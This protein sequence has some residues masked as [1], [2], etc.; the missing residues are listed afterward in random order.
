MDEQEV[1]MQKRV[2]FMLFMLTLTS[3]NALADV[4]FSASDEQWLRERALSERDQNY[5]QLQQNYP[6]LE[7]YTR[8][9]LL[10]NALYHARLADA[11]RVKNAR[12]TTQ[13]EVKTAEHLL[14][15]AQETANAPMED[16]IGTL[17]HEL[18]QRFARYLAG[19]QCQKLTHIGTGP[20]YSDMT[21]LLQDNS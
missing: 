2:L 8:Q 15:R 21:Q 4:N 11:A 9:S 12:A 16:K 20:F 5:E 19:K 1:V 3:V 13:S 7:Q 18:D 6:G 17:E 10:I 14:E